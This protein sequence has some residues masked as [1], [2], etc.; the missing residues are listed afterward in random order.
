MT[1]EEL[2]RKACVLGPYPSCLNDPVGPKPVI[3]MLVFKHIYPMR[4]SA[5]KNWSDE[6]DAE[7]IKE[8]SKALLDA[9]DCFEKQAGEIRELV[10]ELVGDS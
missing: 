2:F 3:A 6:M 1:A 9:A 7:T 8:S 5:I 4:F 10:K